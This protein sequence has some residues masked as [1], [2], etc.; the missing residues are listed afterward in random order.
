MPLQGSAWLRCLLSGPSLK[1][2]LLSGMGCSQGRG[3]EYR[4][5]EPNHAVVVTAL[6]GRGRYH[7]CLH[8]IGQGCHMAKV[9]EL[10]KG[11]HPGYESAACDREWEL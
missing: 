7:V 5:S 2:Q 8:P 6:Q 4:E 11:T 1:E 9:S 3:Q 10:E